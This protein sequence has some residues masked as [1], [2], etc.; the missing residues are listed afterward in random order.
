[1]AGFVVR[2][3]PCSGFL[4]VHS[5][6]HYV[7]HPRARLTRLWNYYTRLDYCGQTAMPCTT[8]GGCFGLDL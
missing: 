3:V 5:G 2:V 1:M 8:D 7:V 4:W 6:S